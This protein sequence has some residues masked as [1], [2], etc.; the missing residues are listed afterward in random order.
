MR[1][2]VALSGGK[3]STALAL[4]LAETE[5]Q[6]YT[7]F[8]TPTGDEL[9]DL[10]E[11]WRRLEVLLGAP[12]VRV[13]CPSLKDTIAAMAIPLHPNGMLPNYR[14]RFCTRLIKIAPARDW[15]AEQ[16]PSVMYVGLRADE[17]ERVGMLEAPETATL[18]FPLREWGWG[19]AEVRAYLAKR[20]VSIPPRT[21]CARCF[22]Q[23]LGEWRSLWQQHPEIYEDAVQ[24]EKRIGHTYRSPGRDKWPAA[25]DLLREEFKRGRKIRGDGKP[26]PDTC[27]AC[28]S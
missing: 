8:I 7:Y 13:P 4:R 25:L 18:R 28:R 22:F 10:V 16:G 27:H 15:V 1:H 14:A 21:D 5:P 23:R 3:D 6:D 17:G 26:S 2:L 19:L 24:D 9:P 11:H 12:L 20:E